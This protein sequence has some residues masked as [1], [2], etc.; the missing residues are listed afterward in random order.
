M[1]RAAAFVLGVAGPAALRRLVGRAVAMLAVSTALVAPAPAAEDQPLVFAAASLTDAMTAVAEAYTA[2]TGHDVALVFASSSAL[3]RQI[4]NGAP[5]A[6]FISANPAWMDRLEVAGLLQAGS[7]SDLLGN[8][9]ALIAPADFAAEASTGLDLVALLDDGRLAMGDPDHVPAGI[10][11]KAALL[12]LGLWEAARP[13]LARTG[14]VR[15]ALALVARGEAPL[16]IVYATDAAATDRVRVVA[17]LPADSHP[18][19]V[20]PAALRAGAGDRARA[21]AGFLRGDAARRIFTAHGFAVPPGP[22]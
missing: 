12:S 14:D 5:A 22:S 10:Y 1:V 6:Q 21:F 7:R 19:I 8:R 11:A 4:E 20:Y 9:L 15:G 2:E 13:R 17:L 18:P 16:G 3:A